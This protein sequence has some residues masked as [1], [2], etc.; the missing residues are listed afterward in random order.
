ML[1]LLQRLKRFWSGGIQWTCPKCKEEFFST[2]SPLT[3]TEQIKDHLTA[4]HGFSW[5]DKLDLFK[6][7]NRFLEAD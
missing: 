1:T 3:L 7:L 6:N 2:G 4:K 5:S